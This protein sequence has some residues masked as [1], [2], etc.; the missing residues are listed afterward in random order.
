MTFMANRNEMLDPSQVNQ[1]LNVTKMGARHKIVHPSDALAS[2]RGELQSLGLGIVREDLAA[3]KPMLDTGYG[4]F[5]AMFHLDL[6]SQD[7]ERQFSVGFRMSTDETISFAACSGTNT[8]VCSN[9]CIMGDW[10][11]TRKHTLNMDLGQLC[12]DIVR[13]AL[14]RY[15]DTEKVIE[16][17]RTIGVGARAAKFAAG[18]ALVAGALSPAQVRDAT[19]MFLDAEK[20]DDVPEVRERNLWGLQSAYTRVVG[21]LP[22]HRRVSASDSVGRLFGSLLQKA[23][24]EIGN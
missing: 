4:K 11:V 22:A 23:T 6:N 3:T 18:E 2:F 14:D 20:R 17:S 24:N 19:V 21:T 10:V 15:M 7:M 16:I 1:I 9:L 13:P 8:L 12:T 5:F